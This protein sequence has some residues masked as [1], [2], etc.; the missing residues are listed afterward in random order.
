VQKPAAGIVF[1]IQRFSIHDGPG[2]RTTV[3]LK[4]CPLRC[5][6]CHNPE[7]LAPKPELSFVPALC[8]GCGYCVQH[9]PNG[10][11]VLVDGTHRLRRELCRGCLQCIVGCYSGALEAVGREMTAEDVIAE[12]VRDRPFYEESGGGMTLSGGEPML[13]FEFSR[14]VLAAARA[15]AL[16]TCIETGGFAPEEQYRSIL[17]FVD[18][19]LYDFKESD[20]AR[21]LA[22][23]G[24]PNELIL[25]NLRLLDAA[26]ARIILRCPL[27]PGC[28]LRDDHLAA[29]ARM[30]QELAHCEAVHVMGYHRLGQSKRARL[31]L[32]AGTAPETEGLGLPEQELVAAIEKLRARGAKNVSRP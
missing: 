16:H 10:A 4:G 11:H 25:R 27:I 3:F 19:F 2:I 21:H 23:T 9:C 30:S 1:D 18:L 26:G 17:P 31:G 20:P 6:W 32:A 15:K 7:S 22:F 24:Q 5:Q 14:A 28:N 12:V 8:I 29:V 13:Q